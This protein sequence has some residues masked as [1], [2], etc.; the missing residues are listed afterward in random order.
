MG[1]QQLGLDQEHNTAK[2]VIAQGCRVSAN[3]GLHLGAC[4]RILGTVPGAN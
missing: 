1:M 3:G 4:P 2:H